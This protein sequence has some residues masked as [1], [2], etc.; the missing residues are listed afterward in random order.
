MLL[1][2]TN[3]IHR[4]SRLVKTL[5]EGPIHYIK[6]S[7]QITNSKQTGKTEELLLRSGHRLD[8]DRS[9]SFH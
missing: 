9:A 7:I 6:K 2:P 3:K 8:A 1:F 4:L 5:S